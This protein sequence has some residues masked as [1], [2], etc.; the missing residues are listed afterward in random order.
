[1][2]H[3]PDRSDRRQPDSP[4]AGRRALPT[5]MGSLAASAIA[6]A[7]TMASAPVAGQDSDL[8]F[9][10]QLGDQPLSGP[11]LSYGAPSGFGMGHG[12]LSFGGAV[13]SRRDRTGDDAD[14]SGSIAVGVGDSENLIGFET[15][16]G[17]I[18]TTN[19]IGKDGNIGFKAFRQLPGFTESGQSSIALGASNAVRWGDAR[20]VDTNFFG[21]ASTVIHLNDA[22]PL[23]SVPLMLTAGYGSAVIDNEDPGGFFSAGLQVHPQI[24]LI[25]SYVGDEAI[26]AVSVVPFVDYRASAT[27]AV[28]DIGGNVSDEPRV[29]FSVGYSFDSLF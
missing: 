21:S 4:D 18:S 8:L 24:S 6:M 10:Q 15:N 9:L 23:N 2:T 19:G 20:D 26:A 12:Q 29:I 27:L 3:R 7:M 5:R 16:L 13:T 25:G 17:I 1:M 11:S 14:A 22:N 28:A